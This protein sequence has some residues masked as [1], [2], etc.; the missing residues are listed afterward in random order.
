MA[1]ERVEYLCREHPVAVGGQM[2]VHL[3]VAGHRGLGPEQVQLDGAALQEQLGE[4]GLLGRE[5]VLAE[6][7]REEPQDMRAALGELR[8]EV[9][10][11]GPL[12]VEVSQGCIV[13][14]Q[15]EDDDRVPRVA[16]LDVTVP[17]A[18]RRAYLDHGGERRPVAVA[19]I[20]EGLL[21]AN[22]DA[23]PEQQERLTRVKPAVWARRGS[24]RRP[25][26]PGARRRGALS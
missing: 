14:A 13:A 21:D 10:D 26:P 11:V 8:D 9:A 25:L 18:G 15:A 5:R 6:R 7:W 3:V 22:P 2:Q 20:V 24:L 17:V 16:R 1:R 23:V 19:Q 4:P 12:R